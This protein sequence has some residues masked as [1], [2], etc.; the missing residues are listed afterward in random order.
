MEYAV[1]VDPA[2][3]IGCRACQVACK[4]WN[5]LPGE[6]TT[7]SP[8]WT[9]PLKLS[10]NT[11]THIKFKFEHN[12]ET[13]EMKWRFF[14]WRC[15]HCKDPA[16]APAC[17]VNAITKYEEGPVVVH[18]DR[19]IGCKFC[20]SAC[21]F[22]IPQFDADT[23]KVS[24]CHMCYNRVPNKEPACVQSCPTDA[25]I[26]GPREDI[27]LKAKK[28]AQELNGHIY[29]DVEVKP[30]G[31]TSFIYVLDSDPS[32]FGLPNVG[33]SV[34]AT[35]SALKYSKFL[36]VPAAVGGLLYLVAWR[37]RRMEEKEE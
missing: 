14:N 5:D 30:L 33:E 12:N 6:V 2:K 11:F 17:P 20:V 18:T 9:N 27:I 19:C 23:G 1:L 34:P 8:E 25:L 29:G 28:R 31:G 24:K 7:F 22:G 37:K 21:P 4:R 26:F 15:M 32:V 35:V 10:F 3:C 13:D 36:L 16:C